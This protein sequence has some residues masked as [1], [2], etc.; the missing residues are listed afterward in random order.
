[1]KVINVPDMK[2]PDSEVKS[3]AFKIFNNLLEVKDY[4]S[5]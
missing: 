3:M 2:M 4:I 1:M 5:K